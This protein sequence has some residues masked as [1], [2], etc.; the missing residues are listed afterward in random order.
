MDRYLIINYLNHAQCDNE[1][2]YLGD[3]GEYQYENILY[4]SH[5]NLATSYL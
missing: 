1:N 2:D 3:Q 4:I 5:Y